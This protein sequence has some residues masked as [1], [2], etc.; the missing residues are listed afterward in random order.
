MKS[1]S[2]F[3]I[4]QICRNCIA[5]EQA[6]VAIPAIDSEA[7]QQRLDRVRTYYELLNMPFEALLAF[8]AEHDTLFTFSEYSSLLKVNIPG[9]DI[10]ADAV[11]RIGQILAP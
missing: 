6:L 10:P 7:V 8:V 1:I 3:G 4:R 9:R 11:Q 2:L 5:L